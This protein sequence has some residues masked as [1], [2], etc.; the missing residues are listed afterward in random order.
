MREEKVLHHWRIEVHGII[1]M[2]LYVRIHVFIQGTA[3]L[4]LMRE[5]KVPR[6]WLFEARSITQL[7][8][9]DGTMHLDFM[10]IPFFMAKKPMVSVI[11]LVVAVAEHI[12]GARRRS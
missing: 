11:Y 7:P 9:Y 6:H 2:L 3:S 12:H 1:L 10:Q 4:G 5:E 8:P